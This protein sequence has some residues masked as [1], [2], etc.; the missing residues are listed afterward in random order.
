[1]YRSLISSFFSFIHLTGRS[2]GLYLSLHTTAPDTNPSWR[3][4]RLLWSASLPWR[5][6]R[7]CQIYVYPPSQKTQKTLL[8][9]KTIIQQSNLFNLRYIIHLLTNQ[10]YDSLRS[11]SLGMQG[12]TIGNISDAQWLIVYRLIGLYLGRIRLQKDERTVITSHWM[13]KQRNNLQ[14]YEYLCHI[15]EAKE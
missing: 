5:V 11:C 2:S 9:C 6:E 1:M 14:A 13:D 12:T 7:T 4:D 8:V 15:G 10:S 3:Q